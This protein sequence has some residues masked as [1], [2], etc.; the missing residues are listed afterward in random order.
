[1]Y[2]EEPGSQCGW[3]GENDE[4][5]IGN[6]V[7]DVIVLPPKRAWG[8]GGRSYKDLAFHSKTLSYIQ[9]NQQGQMIFF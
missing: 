3:D 8:S 7:K 9:R 2:K 1:M 6:E 4:K 5:E